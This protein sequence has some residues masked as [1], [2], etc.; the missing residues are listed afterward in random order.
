M[1]YNEPVNSTQ[2]DFALIPRASLSVG[3]Y[4]RDFSNTLANKLVNSIDKGFIMP[5]VVTAA[6]DKY[7]IIDGQHRLA[8]FDKMSPESD[9]LPCIIVPEYYRDYPLFYNIEKTDNIKDKSVKLYHL[10]KDKMANPDLTEKDIVS[11]ANYEA[12]LFTIAIAY[13]QYG[14]KSPSLVESPIKKLDKTYLTVEDSDGYRIGMP[15]KDAWEIRTE[16]AAMARRLEEV[17]T[18]TAEDYGVRDFNLKRAIVSKSSQAL[19]GSRRAI[20]EP[21]EEALPALTEQITMMDWSWMAGR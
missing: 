7:E 18:E 14:L 21:F 8:A 19:W 3:T 20:E 5:L 11:A 17:V 9:E 6:G 4:Q 10:Y 15:L 2:Y 16:R 12:Y 13:M 1:K